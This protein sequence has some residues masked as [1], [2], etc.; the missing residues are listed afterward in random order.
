MTIDTLFYT[1]PADFR[2]D[3]SKM[4]PYLVDRTGLRLPELVAAMRPLNLKWDEPSRVLTQ[5][6][7][8]PP[9]KRHVRRKQP[10]PR[11]REVLALLDQHGSLDQDQLAEVLQ[12]P[13]LTSRKLL[14]SV[15][16]EG[17]ASHTDFRYKITKL[18]RQ[19]TTDVEVRI[20]VQTPDKVRELAASKAERQVLDL[21]SQ[22]EPRDCRAVAD[23][24]GLQWYWVSK[25]LRRLHRQGRVVKVNTPGVGVVDL[26]LSK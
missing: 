6:E 10:K 20:G 14:W 8:K 24:L 21:L 18:G 23:Q 1:A 15:A 26:Y 2:A 7:P 17:W 4:I 11:E 22:T 3:P 16:R 5:P 19:H 13:R 25:L 9:K 12:I